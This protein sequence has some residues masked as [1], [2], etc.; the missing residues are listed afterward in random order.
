MRMKTAI[1]LSNR[2]GPAG[3]KEIIDV[4][5]TDWRFF[6]VLVLTDMDKLKDNPTQEKEDS[7]Q[8]VARSTMHMT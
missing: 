8:N 7:S 2:S 1:L 5:S 3:L 4:R 6:P